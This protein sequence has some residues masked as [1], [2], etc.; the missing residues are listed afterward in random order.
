MIENARMYRERAMHAQLGA[1][2]ATSEQHREISESL[3]ISVRVHGDAAEWTGGAGDTLSAANE[4]RE[5]DNTLSIAPTIDRRATLIGSAS[6][7]SSV[8]VARTFFDEKNE[9]GVATARGCEQTH[10][11]HA[12]LTALFLPV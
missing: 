8:K 9:F 2:E 3:A 6:E 10:K 1:K 12:M 4:Q 11:G 5:S 7:S